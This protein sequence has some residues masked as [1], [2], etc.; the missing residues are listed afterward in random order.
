[1][2]CGSG[3][4]GN[5]FLSSC[6]IAL[7][8]ICR[9]LVCL[10]LIISVA[11][12]RPCAIQDEELA[13]PSSFSSLINISFHSFDLDFPIECD[14]EYWFT[15]GRDEE[16]FSPAFLKQPVVFKQPVDK[17]SLI[18]AF[19]WSLKLYKVLAVLVRTMVSIC[20]LLSPT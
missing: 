7:T 6:A 2:R 5:V 8:N 13:S 16:P 18:T 15:S 20:L 17:P 19:V 10:D 12:G 3:R 9:V 4:F 14:D 1:M 11:L